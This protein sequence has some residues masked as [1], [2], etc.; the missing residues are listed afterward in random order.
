M[1]TFI[2]VLEYSGPILLADAVASRFP[3][4]EH[5]YDLNAGILAGHAAGDLPRVGFPVRQRGWNTPAQTIRCSVCDTVVQ[6]V[7]RDLIVA[8]VLSITS[9]PKW[10]RA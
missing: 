9:R 1:Q 4:C 3:V 2:V 8:A 7:V 10:T 6:R 5:A